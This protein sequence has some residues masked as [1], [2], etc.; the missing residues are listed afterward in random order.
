M[1]RNRGCSSSRMFA[2]LPV[3]RRS[4]QCIQGCPALLHLLRMCPVIDSDV[5]ALRLVIVCYLQSPY[6]L[7]SR[8][9]SRLTLKAQ[10]LIAVRHYVVS[11]C[12]VVIPFYSLYSRS[13]G[14]RDQFV[15]HGQLQIAL[16]DTAAH[17]PEFDV[18]R[19][20]LFSPHDDRYQAIVAESIGQFAVKCYVCRIE[21]DL[22]DIG[23]SITA[24]G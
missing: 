10:T 21:R 17:Q 18:Q 24:G 6:G 12:M 2:M 9:I 20:A 5:S 13:T 23:R 3:E 15:Q 8:R 1:S 4:S 7:A 22:L 16:E 19:T 14:S 11:R